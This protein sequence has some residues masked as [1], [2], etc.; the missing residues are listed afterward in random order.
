MKKF[1]FL[2]AGIV[3][4]FI[5]ICQSSV[6][7]QNIQDP[8]FSNQYYLE[9]INAIDAWD[10]TKGDSSIIVTITDQPIETNHED[11]DSSRIKRIIGGTA[12]E[13][14]AHG[15]AVAGI[16]F[17]DHNDK[18]IAGIAPNVSIVGVATR[19]MFGAHSDIELKDF[20][21]T[22]AEEGSILFN[23]S[24][25]NSG[26]FTQYKDG[27]IKQIAYSD[28]IHIAAAG[29]KGEQIN[30]VPAVFSDMYVV[31]AIDQSLNRWGWSN[32]GIE[33]KIVGP[34]GEIGQNIV[35]QHPCYDGI[36][37]INLGLEAL[38]M[39]GDI[40]TLD[41]SGQS[42]YNPGNYNVN[43]TDCWGNF[44]HEYNPVSNNNYMNDFSG[45]SANA[46]MVTGTVALMLSV[47]PNLN[48][49]A[50]F[51][52]LN[53]TAVKVPAMGTNN[54]DTLYGYGMLDVY[55]AVKEALPQQYDDHTFSNSTTIQSAHIDGTTTLGSGVTLTV[56]AN[57][58]SVLE[59]TITGA[60]TNT[61]LKVYGKLIVDYDAT[62]SRV[63]M[64][65]E[66]GGEVL[67][68]PGATFEL[69]TGQWNNVWV[70]PG[71][72]ITAH[73]TQANPIT[74]TRKDAGTSWSQI[75]LQSSEENSFEWVVFDGGNKTVG[76]ASQNNIFKHCTFK[77]GV[78]GLSGWHNQDGS[79]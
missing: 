41:L 67:I 30:A 66:D 26:Q 54:F 21:I 62:I 77:N 18:G 36:E 56:A 7:A 51:T 11:M 4:H 24:W 58:V 47:N 57:E 37:S 12:F 68:K 31:G 78:R 43:T 3:L 55:A 46:P 19:N 72:K 44:E 70:K 49:D 75:G 52:I 65:V 34:N 73:G 59:G 2:V 5:M 50:I 38:K 14:R 9:M 79:G 60:A 25:E 53:N 10:I 45:T 35:E 20:S 8:Y 76:I 39:R 71:G 40:W 28:I 15:M 48:R 22:A 6:L 13:N 29:N 69:S 27:F 74:F 42:G 16:M 17:A 61:H 1:A 32:Y 64:E 23:H 63:H 33:L